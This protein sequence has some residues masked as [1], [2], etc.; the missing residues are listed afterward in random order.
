MAR[1]PVGGIYGQLV[2]GHS[3]QA[4]QPGQPAW[5]DANGIHG[6][7]AAIA[8]YKRYFLFAVDPY[9]SGIFISLRD[10][11]IDTRY[12]EVGTQVDD[13]SLLQPLE[14]NTIAHSIPAEEEN[15]IDKTGYD[16]RGNICF[17]LHVFIG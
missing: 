14:G 16:A 10:I 11:G 7:G 1:S 8:E 13:D 9:G 6:R 2:G 15:R 5:P 3:G 4:G 12:R 17:E